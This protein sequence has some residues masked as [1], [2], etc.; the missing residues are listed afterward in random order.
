M[1][2]EM[3]ST[4]LTEMYAANYEEFLRRER[5]WES[6]ER[7]KIMARH[8]QDRTNVLTGMRNGVLLLGAIVGAAIWI[9][10]HL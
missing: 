5:L 9:I 2:P 7:E 1:N 4:E 6:A 8:E 10:L 3:I